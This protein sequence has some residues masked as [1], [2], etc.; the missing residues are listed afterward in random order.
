[1]SGFTAA[2]KTELTPHRIPI[3]M[4]MSDATTKPVKTVFRLVAIWSK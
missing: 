2:R 3:G 4:A 1:M